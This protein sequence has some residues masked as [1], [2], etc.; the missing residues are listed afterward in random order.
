MF[1]FLPSSLKL[2][3][4]PQIYP[5]LSYAMYSRAKPEGS[6]ARETI[7]VGVLENSQEVD[8]SAKDLDLG[9]YADLNAYKFRKYFIIQVFKKDRTTILEFVKRYQENTQQRLVG[10]RM[11]SYNY[12]SSKDG[13]KKTENAVQEN[14]ID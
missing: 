4:D 7:L 10:L 14:S 2:A 1:S 13:I 12:T 8:I 9:N 3:C 11:K 6:Q 5:F